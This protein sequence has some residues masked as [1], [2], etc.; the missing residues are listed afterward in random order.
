MLLQARTPRPC[1]ATRG[2]CRGG[3]QISSRVTAG[4][5]CHRCHRRRWRGQSA[6]LLYQGADKPV[7]EFISHNDQICEGGGAACRRCYLLEWLGWMGWFFSIS[8]CWDRGH[9][10]RAPAGLCSSVC[11]H[12]PP[13]SCPCPMLIPHLQRSWFG[14]AGHTGNV[15]PG[16][17]TLACD[18]LMSH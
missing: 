15:T 9:C 11:D 10:R 3:T 8:S 2:Y 7:P 5:C 4:R 16:A 18:G 12:L 1:R 6:E 17:P 13:L 14:Q